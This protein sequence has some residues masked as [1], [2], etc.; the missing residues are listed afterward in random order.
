MPDIG[1]ELKMET[2]RIDIGVSQF[3]QCLDFLGPEGRGRRPAN[4]KPTATR[5]RKRVGLLP[6]V[7][8]ATGTLVQVPPAAAQTPTESATPPRID[9]KHPLTFH[10]QYYPPQSITS[11]EE[12]TCFVALLVDIDG[13]INAVQ[14]LNL[15]RPPTPRRSLHRLCR[16][17]T[18]AP[19]RHQREVRRRM[20]HDPYIMGL[21]R[22][23]KIRSPIHGGLGDSKTARVLR[24]AGRLQVLPR[25]RT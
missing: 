1:N 12:G 2:R 20:V 22:Q 3:G 24:T 15:H 5:P 7:F 25:R 21:S 19:G 11:G 23:E 6:I 18:D 16:E 8:L 9:P 14:L 13:Q 10:Y 17:R 4:A